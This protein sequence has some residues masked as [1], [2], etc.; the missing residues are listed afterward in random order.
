[1]IFQRITTNLEEMIP[2]LSAGEV[3][4]TSMLS[5]LGAS[6]VD[7]AELI[8]RIRE[9]MGLKADRFDFHSAEN[10]GELSEMLASCYAMERST[11]GRFN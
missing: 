5:L 1:M 8:E 6:S 10:L 4:E 11:D 9:E 3:K 2:G 7:R